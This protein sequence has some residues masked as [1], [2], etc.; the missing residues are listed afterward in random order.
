VQSHSCSS[1]VLMRVL[2]FYKNL[3]QPND[4]AGRQSVALHGEEEQAVQGPAAHSGRGRLAAQASFLLQSTFRAISKP[5]LEKSTQNT[6]HSCPCSVQNSTLKAFGGK[7]SNYLR[8]SACYLWH[9]D[10]IYG[11]WAVFSR[12]A[13]R[14]RARQT[15]W[16]VTRPSVLA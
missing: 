6:T 9:R 13:G 11:A 3:F 10:T 16:T 7:K 8:V 5:T 14:L 4:M 1:E 12:T 2:S 15:L